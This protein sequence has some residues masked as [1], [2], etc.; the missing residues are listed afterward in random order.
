MPRI[1][2]SCPARGAASEAFAPASAASAAGASC[3]APSRERRSAPAPWRRT[4]LLARGAG[5][6]LHLGRLL[7]DG[8]GTDKHQPAVQVRTI[9]LKPGREPL[10]HAF[11][12]G[13][14]AARGCSRTPRTLVFLLSQGRKTLT[15]HTFPLAGN[16]F[17]QHLAV[18]LLGFASLPSCAERIASHVRPRSD[19]G[20]LARAVSRTVLASAGMFPSFPW[21]APRKAREQMVVLSLFSTIVLLLIVLISL[22]PMRAFPPQSRAMRT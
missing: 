22:P 17:A 3:P 13:A 1:M 6:F 20:F 11:D 21:P 12:H 19:C 4:K 10:D 16:V 5:C 14:L 8:V 7:Q 9:L 2:A 15:E 18:N